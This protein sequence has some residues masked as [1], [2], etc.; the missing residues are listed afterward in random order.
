[1]NNFSRQQSQLL[2]PK[3]SLDLSKGLTTMS[4]DECKV[5]SYQKIEFPTYF[6]LVSANALKIHKHSYADSGFCY[7]NGKHFLMMVETRLT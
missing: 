4:R 6:L 5:M 2:I 3:Q 1:M 7:L